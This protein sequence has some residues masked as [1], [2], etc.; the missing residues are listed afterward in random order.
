MTNFKITRT[1]KLL[2]E[3]WIKSQKIKDPTQFVSG[4]RWEYKFVPTGMGLL[5]YAFDC[6][7]EEE[8]I[9]RGTENW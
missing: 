2:I 4:G 6:V 1:E 9:V 8:L 3:T 7:T 5:I